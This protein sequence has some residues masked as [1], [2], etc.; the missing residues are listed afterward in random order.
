MPSQLKGGDI[1]LAKTD[2]GHSLVF[3]FVC[4]YG[5]PD[6][7]G[8]DKKIFNDTALN[9]F[10]QYITLNNMFVYTGSYI[11]N[12]G[13]LNNEP[14]PVALLSVALPWEIYFILIIVHGVIY[15]CMY[16]SRY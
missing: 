15:N 8:K 13:T 10:V 9:T 3:S 1:V 12:S 16:V 6:T 14:L 5:T 7:F 2:A 4:G 11:L